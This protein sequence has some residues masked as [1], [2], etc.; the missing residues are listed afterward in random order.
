MEKVA[1]ASSQKYQ[2]LQIGT[3]FSKIAKV[4]AKLWPSMDLL[5]CFPSFLL[6]T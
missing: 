1:H 6:L 2:G 5:A 4:F 3:L